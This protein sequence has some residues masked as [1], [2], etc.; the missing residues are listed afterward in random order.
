M[1]YPRPI[2]QCQKKKKKKKKCWQ[3]SFANNGNI[4]LLPYENMSFRKKKKNYN[5]LPSGDW[6]DIAPVGAHLSSRTCGPLGL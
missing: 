2:M 4:Y 3:I 1:L 6:K 5:N